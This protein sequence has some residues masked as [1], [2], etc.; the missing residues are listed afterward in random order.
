MDIDL[1][2]SF[3]FKWSHPDVF[4]FILKGKLRQK[5]NNYLLFNI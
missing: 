2:V 4:H 5:H 3:Y 1:H